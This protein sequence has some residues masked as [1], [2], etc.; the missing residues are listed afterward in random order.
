LRNALDR[1]D[2]IHHRR[3]LKLLNKWIT[4]HLKKRKPAHPFG[5]VGAIKGY[6]YDCF[7]NENQ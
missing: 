6:E 7:S 3:A 5:V 2:S 4:E 1:E